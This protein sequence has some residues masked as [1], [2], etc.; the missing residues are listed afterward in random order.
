MVPITSEIAVE[1]T[2]TS[3]LFFVHVRNEVSQR[4]FV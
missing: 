1:S 3:R 2:V 4:S